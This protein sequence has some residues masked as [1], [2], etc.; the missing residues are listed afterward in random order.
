MAKKREIPPESWVYVLD[1]DKKLPPEE[2]TRWTL[3]PMTQSE[4]ARFVDDLVRTHVSEDGG[5][6]VIRRTEQQALGLC[7]TH[8]VS[9][10][11]FPAGSNGASQAWPKG[12]AER[13][14]YL[15]MV[16]AADILE[17]GNEV[18]VRSTAGP[19]AKN[20]SPPGLTSSSGGKSADLASTT[21]PS[22]ERA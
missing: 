21:A 7:L 12:Q 19:D 1:A 16:D 13:E 15:E 9:V 11:N 20:S 6:T 2:Q 17:L 10:E 5:Q 22:A 8:I 3:S 4:R 14:R 18:Y